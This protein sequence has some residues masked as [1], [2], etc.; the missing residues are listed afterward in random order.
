MKTPL[1]GV[2]FAL[3]T[4][5]AQI[6]PG[7]VPFV[8]DTATRLS[9]AYDH[10][11]DGRTDVIDLNKEQGSFSLGLRQADGSF[12]W[13]TPR[14][15]GFAPVETMAVGR[16]ITSSQFAIAVTSHDFNNIQ[17]VPLD[18]SD[19]PAPANGALPPE[20]HGLATIPISTGTHALA[21]SFVAAAGDAEPLKMVRHGQP[22]GL[23]TNYEPAPNARRGAT[24]YTRPGSPPVLAFAA[25]MITPGAAQVQFFE[26][27]E[28]Y[29]DLLTEWLT[30][31]ALPDAVRF[32]QGFFQPDVTAQ[33][34]G[35]ESTTLL[36]WT[37]GSPTLR[38]A[39]LTNVDLPNSSPLAG[40]ELFPPAARS[41]HMQ[42]PIRSVYVLL[43][44]GASTRLLI[45]W[46]DAGG[47]ASIH[48][49]D[50]DAVPDLVE[51][52]GL[53]NLIADGFAPLAGGDFIAL[54]QR[55][56]QPVHE[57]YSESTPGHYTALHTGTFPVLP[58]K[59]LYSNVVAFQGE[60]M[61]SPEA[62][63]LKR[64]RV[65]D[66]STAGTPPA[67]PGG[68][69]ASITSL[70]DTGLT[71]G[72][73]SSS[74]SSLSVPP[75]TTHLLLNQLGPNASMAFVSARTA[76]QSTLPQVIFQPPPGLY[77]SLAPGQSFAVYITSPGGSFDVSTI[78]SVNG[79]AWI[80]GGRFDPLLLTGNATVRA[81]AFSY[82]TGTG[83]IVTAT[84]TFG[85]VPAPAVQST[86]DADMNGLSDSWE[87]LTGIHDPAG[88]ADGDGFLNLAEH[89]AGFDPNNP[90]SKPDAVAVMPGLDVRQSVSTGP[91]L[92]WDASDTAILLETSA[93]LE[94]WTLVTHGTR[95]EGGERV[96]DL[97][98]NS[99]PRRFY[100]LRR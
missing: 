8:H 99:F 76:A 41:F 90:L 81:Y 68:E 82:L 47:G 58:N 9:A 94:D 83:P 60:P 22:Y 37:P 3:S 36:A 26:A 85:T 66:W 52:L 12:V 38:I 89:N 24:L 72:L 48:S 70:T 15:V 75:A 91:S 30:S 86:P 51:G 40:L 69:T 27:N 71:T 35:Y 62:S 64:A 74:S 80:N 34:G 11:G 1:G 7:G 33:G 92:R 56:G 14:S 42:R 84:Y 95:V 44:P 18:G 100:R 20:P 10:N 17:F 6:V 50:G 25:D 98:V 54:G 67:A 57:V 46:A 13:S 5:S 21:A 28:N 73:G 23:W 43:A 29:A 77:P 79:G 55:N 19:L 53:N 2:A 32:T 45:T 63:A 96:F 61:V 39:R 88:D 59:A 78:Y 93:N 4:V 49:F 87:D 31:P 16:F 97:P 65:A